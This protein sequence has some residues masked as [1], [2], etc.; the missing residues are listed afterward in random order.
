MIFDIVFLV[1]I[2]VGFWWGYQKGIIYSLFSLAAYFIGIMAALKFSYIAVKFLSGSLHLGPKAMAIAAFVLVFALVVLLV[3]LIAWALEAVLKS[4]SL[5]LVNQI[6]G[7][8]LHALVSLYI[9]CVFIWFVNK[10]DVISLEQKRTSHVYG[11]I[12]DL[13]PTVVDYTGKAVPA[14]R[15]LFDDFDELISRP[16]HNS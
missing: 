2:A 3:R 7:G 11:Y 10:W 5:N 13:G 1:F 15:H 6:V 16:I 9:L 4:F 14:I 12:A 8:C